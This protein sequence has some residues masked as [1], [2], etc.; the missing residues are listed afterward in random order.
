MK[1]LKAYREQHPEKSYK[2]CMM[3][4][5][6]TYKKSGS[7]LKLAGEGAHGG[8]LK[9]AG[10]GDMAPMLEDAARVLV[11]YTKDVVSGNLAKLRDNLI[12]LYGDKVL[13]GGIRTGGQY[14]SGL[15]LAGGVDWNKL[16]TKALTLLSQAPVKSLAKKGAQ[17][18]GKQVKVLAKKALENP[19]KTIEVLSAGVDLTKS[20]KKK[21]VRKSGKE[22]AQ[23]KELAETGK[24]PTKRI[25][26][27]PDPR[28]PARSTTSAP[29]SSTT[30]KRK[31][32]E[33]KMLKIH[34]G[35]AM[36]GGVFG[37]NLRFLD[38]AKMVKSLGPS[39]VAM[40]LEKSKI[41]D[42][43]IIKL[44]KTKAGRDYVR[45]A[46]HVDPRLKKLQREM[47]KAEMGKKGGALKLAGGQD[48]GFAI[49][50]ALLISGA[51]A[52]AKAVALGAAMAAG[53][54]AVE[55]IVEAA[56]GEP[57]AEV[58]VEYEYID[59]DGNP[60]S[61]GSLLGDLT[62]ATIKKLSPAMKEIGKT[63]DDSVRAVKSVSDKKIVSKMP[64]V[65][66]REAEKLVKRVNEGKMKAEEAVKKFA[67]KRVEKALEKSLDEVQTGSGLSLAG[68]GYGSL[69]KGGVKAGIKTAAKVAKKIIKRVVKK[70]GSVAGKL[71][72]SLKRARVKPPP[73]KGYTPQWQQQ[74]DS[75]ARAGLKAPVKAAKGLD[76][77]AAVEMAKESGDDALLKGIE[78]FMKVVK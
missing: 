46:E 21:G 75:M 18:A 17:V 35:G 34:E 73:A 76:F 15:G 66:M 62:K 69:I 26:S 1:H 5:K 54:L 13:H 24:V 77:S 16:W 8:A 63:V 39:L 40:A 11:R 45:N 10:E 58:A 33:T 36:T 47:I 20:I 23:L 22:V 52:T 3:E 32:G 27:A 30:K 57:E 74:F 31:K 60:I 65:A 9:L 51:I 72:K 42:P 49:T 6:K 38:P 68:G 71:G 56:R 67:E 55:A 29:S 48:G 2:E 78:S 44:L 53:G 50:T 61:G 70:V 64:Q 12:A 7:G 25:K 37:A 19:E 4:A 59:E 28:K 14:G 41:V 43:K